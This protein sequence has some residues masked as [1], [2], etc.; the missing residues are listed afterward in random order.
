M[1]INER[2]ELLKIKINFELDSLS[3]HK[4][5]A[6]LVK[7]LREKINKFK[8][9]E[10]GK[11][12]YLGYLETML[13]YNIKQLNS[14]VAEGRKNI[15]DDR[16]EDLLEKADK[17]EKGIEELIA[18]LNK[19]IPEVAHFAEEKYN[20]FKNEFK[21]MLDE[22]FKYN[23]YDLYTSLG[24]DHNINLSIYGGSANLYKCYVRTLEVFKTTELAR[25]KR[26]A[27]NDKKIKESIDKA[28]KLIKSGDLYKVIVELEKKYK[29]KLDES[30]SNYLVYRTSG[31]VDLQKEVLNKVNEIDKVTAEI[32]KQN[33]YR[34]YLNSININNVDIDKI[35]EIQKYVN[36]NDA[37][38]DT[39]YNV[40]YVLVEKEK[41]I[42]NKYN[43]K[44]KLID[45]LSKETMIK[46]ERLFVERISLLDEDEIQDALREYKEN[47]YLNTNDRIVIKE[48]EKVGIKNNSTILYKIGKKDPVGF[49]RLCTSDLLDMEETIIKHNPKLKFKLRKYFRGENLHQVDE[50][51]FR[52]TLDN[53]GKEENIYFDLEGNRNVT[54]PSSMKLSGRVGNFYI[55]S[56]APLRLYDA[57]SLGIIFIEQNSLYAKNGGSYG[58]DDESETVIV[59]TLSDNDEHIY[60]FDYKGN[61]IAKCKLSDVIKQMS[62]EKGIKYTS[63]RFFTEYFKDGV[64]GLEIKEEG[65]DS[66]SNFLYNIK[67]MEDIVNIISDKESGDPTK[68]KDMIN[69]NRY[70]CYRTSD[71]RKMIGYCDSK[72]NTV[73][74]KQYLEGTAFAGGMA[75]VKDQ[76]GKHHMIDIFGNYINCGIPLNCSS[77]S[78]EPDCANDRFIIKLPNGDYYSMRVDNNI[79]LNDNKP[80]ISYIKPMV[81]ESKTYSKKR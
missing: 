34:D 42:K 36:D 71:S 13:D 11:I 57:S 53:K 58:I 41:Y 7:G 62:E 10:K 40:L 47:G 74:S 27:D 44:Y 3:Y 14:M 61:L 78:Y 69:N 1:D 28:K 29:D 31:I 4:D 9:A 24:L 37:L 6:P 48:F 67:T 56:D 52:V 30:S 43:Q 68:F 23:K 22:S 35:L 64:I 5:I 45:K 33:G 26:F 18:Y 80:L 76:S 55:S 75:Y 16:S 8:V 70:S 63:G 39:F 32:E 54:I 81:Q 51:L 79:V 38:E 73:I 17:N 66:Y 46:L 65:K 20:S 2:I 12:A 15:Y 77:N 25:L 19:N 21:S 59:R 49:K 72:G 60:E 50:N